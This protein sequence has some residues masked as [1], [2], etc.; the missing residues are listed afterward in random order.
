M[1][2]YA[3][4]L[5]RSERP[6]RHH[7][8]FHS[9]V[10]HSDGGQPPS[11]GARSRFGFHFMNHRKLLTSFVPGMEAAVLALWLALLSWV[12]QLAHR[13]LFP[14]EL[15]TVVSSR[16]LPSRGM[17][18]AWYATSGGGTQR[19]R[20]LGEWARSVLAVPPPL[21]SCWLPLT[22]HAPVVSSA[23]CL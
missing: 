7:I 9:E 21:V 15:S 16:R 5:P 23:N 18:F 12:R 22:T 13:W 20:P 19:H 11:A 4:G 3:S 2:Q 17:Q 6:S 10:T 1:R 8:I 14:V